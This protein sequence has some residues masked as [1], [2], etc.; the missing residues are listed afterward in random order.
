MVAAQ[1]VYLSVRIVV[2]HVHGREGAR[3]TLVTTETARRTLREA[4]DTGPAVP[5][6]PWQ[7]Q[8]DGWFNGGSL[9]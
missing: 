1:V 8:R 4:G 7:C 3:H 9:L 6:L 5:V 2:L